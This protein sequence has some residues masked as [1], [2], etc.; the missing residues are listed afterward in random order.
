V[1]VAGFGVV[2]TDLGQQGGIFEVGFELGDV[3]AD[4]FGDRQVGGT[5]AVVLVVFPLG[6]EQAPMESLERVIP[7]ELRGQRRLEGGAAL[8]AN[9]ALF[10]PQTPFWT[11]GGVYLL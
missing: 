10:F 2:G 7:L 6:F 9:A 11:I 1:E 5:A 3:E 4:R 8:G